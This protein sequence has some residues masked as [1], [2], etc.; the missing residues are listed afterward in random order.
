MASE[1]LQQDGRRATG[2]EETAASCGLR[3]AAELVA[4]GC[5]LLPLAA[6]CCY[7]RPAVIPRRQAPAQRSVSDEGRDRDRPDRGPRFPVPRSR[8]PSSPAAC[9]LPPGFV[10]D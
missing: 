7:Y 9:H 4:D 5:A 6:G 1:G 3:A 10:G 8:F 2:D